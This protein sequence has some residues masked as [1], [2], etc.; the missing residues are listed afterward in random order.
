MTYGHKF[1]LFRARNG[2]ISNSG[3]NT[4]DFVP[5]H[6]IILIRARKHLFPCPFRGPFPVRA[7]KVTKHA[8]KAKRESETGKRNG[9]IQNASPTEEK[10]EQKESNATLKGRIE[11]LT[12]AINAR[13][14]DPPRRPRGQESMTLTRIAPGC[15]SHAT[16]GEGN[17][18]GRMWR[19]W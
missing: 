8:A 14:H 9:K 12:S 11:Q 2:I 7:R 15:R 4:P 19:M 5:I 13:R 17:S 10:R 3:T 6:G 18:R 1:T 16:P